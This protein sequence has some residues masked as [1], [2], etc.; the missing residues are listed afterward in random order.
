MGYDFDKDVENR[1]P[2]VWRKALTNAKARV[3]AQEKPIGILL[4]GQP[5]AG[6]SH[7]TKVIR[8]LLNGN[9]IVI[10]GDE[11][12]PYKQR[13]KELPHFHQRGN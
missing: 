1:F 13:Y 6:K 2:A 3:T 5:G 7:G 12:R 11:F 10:N 9:V 8:E 4:G